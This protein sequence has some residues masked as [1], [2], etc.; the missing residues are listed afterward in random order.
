MESIRLN[1]TEE[2]SKLIDI[3]VKKQVILLDMNLWRNSYS[4]LQNLS[5]L[6]RFSRKLPLLGNKNEGEES[7]S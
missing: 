2:E 5:F 3:Y 4:T 7:F 1:L 6:N